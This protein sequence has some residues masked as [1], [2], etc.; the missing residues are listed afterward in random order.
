[1]LWGIQ[2]NK[3]KKKDGKGRRAAIVANDTFSRSG[4][5]HLI[6]QSTFVSEAKQ[7]NKTN[8]N[9]LLWPLPSRFY[10]TNLHTSSG[11]VRTEVLKQSSLDVNIPYQI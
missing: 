4:G 5:R 7:K 2:H 9:T 10:E 1:M 8:N 3:K 6:T 11:F